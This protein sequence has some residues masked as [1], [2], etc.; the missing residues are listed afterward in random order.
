MA[1]WVRIL[2]LI[3]DDYPVVPCLELD[4]YALVYSTPIY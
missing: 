2:A 4:V 3:F 1:F